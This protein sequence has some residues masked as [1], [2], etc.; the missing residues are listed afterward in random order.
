MIN[1]DDHTRFT[2][3]DPQGM[4]AEIDGLP[5]QLQTAWR[6]GQ[7][8][9]LPA[10]QG[11]Q[12]VL[13]SGMGGSAIGADLVAAYILPVCK[14][15]V[16]IHRDYGLP[17]W[18]SGPETLV[19]ACSHSGSTEET[20]TSF[21]QALNA[22]CRCLAFTT[23]GRLAGMARQAGTPLWTFEHSGQPRAAVGYTFG[24][25]LAAFARLGLIG[26]PSVELE[27]AVQAMRRQQETIGAS[28]PVVQ[29][30]AKRLAGQFMDR[31]VVVFG[32]GLLAPVARR[33]KGQINE[34]AKA[35]AQFEL[36]PEADHNTLAGTANPE[37]LISR[38]LT[39]FLSAPSEHPRNQ[40]RTGL[41]R[42]TFMLEGMN[43]DLIEAKGDSALAHMWTLLHLGDYTAYYLAMVYGVDPT[44]VT[45]LEE[46]KYELGDF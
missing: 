30:L 31:W 33:W 4:L 17:A 13:I 40:L 15:P 34:V 45:I 5:D 24:L 19:I 27:D 12:N 38:T 28:V 10:W 20:L 16:F 25:L 3:L 22:G 8:Q 46:F 18:A 32:S 2:Q 42:K 11:I 36:L 21:E 26:D 43:T 44:P 23:G 6:L 9:E 35:W 29:N 7:A 37:A 14:A 1:L 39:I 41:T